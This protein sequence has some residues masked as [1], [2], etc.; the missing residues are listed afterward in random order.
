M[1][2]ALKYEMAARANRLEVLARDL[3]KQANEL[4]SA[5]GELRS[6]ARALALEAVR[7]AEFTQEVS[8]G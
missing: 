2:A 8:R 5:A 3:I 1:N 7:L 4:E 6:R